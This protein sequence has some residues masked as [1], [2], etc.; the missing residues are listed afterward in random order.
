MRK[1]KYYLEIDGKSI[2]LNGD[3][4]LTDYI[5]NNIE[6]I[7][8]TPKHKIKH[9]LITK[10]QERSIEI[11]KRITS[12]DGS[13]D[14]F[15]PYKFLSK[16]HLI[17]GKQKL[18]V[19]EFRQE[20]Y[21]LKL[22]E[23]LKNEHPEWT[24]QNIKVEIDK[25]LKANS[26]MKDLAYLFKKEF[27]LRFYTKT[28]A[29]TD[30]LTSELP[31]IIKNIVLYNASLK[32]IEASEEEIKEAVKKYS[33][34]IREH[35]DSKIEKLL[36]RESLI[37]ANQDIS[38]RDFSLNSEVEM[39]AL[40]DLISIDENG[41][42]NIFEIAVS[43]V[44]YSKWDNVKKDT[45]DY[46][47]G[48]KRQL[49]SNYLDVSN[50]SLSIINIVI[51]KFDDSELINLDGF[52]INDDIERAFSVNNTAT[53]STKSQLHYTEGVISANLKLLLPSAIPQSRRPTKEFV[54]ST[55]NDLKIIFP[56]YEFKSKLTL[57]VEEEIKRVLKKNENNTEVSIYDKTNRTKITIKKDKP[58][59][60]EEFRTKVTEYVNSWNENKDSRMEGIIKD[61]TKMKR[62][63]SSNKSEFVSWDPSIIKGSDVLK[64]A[65][66][67][68][69]HPEW[70]LQNNQIDGLSQLGILLFHNTRTHSIEAVSV[71]ANELNKV[72]NLGDRTSSLLGKFKT[73]RQAE[74]L[75]ILPAKGSYIE[76]VKVL[77]ALSNLGDILKGKKLKS[78]H[79]VSLAPFKEDADIVITKTIT[80]NYNTITSVLN[81]ELEGVSLKNS[82]INNKILLADPFEELYEKIVTNSFA[83]MSAFGVQ[84]NVINI[85]KS[86]NV[87]EETPTTAEE[88]L[89]WFE[90]LQDILYNPE[91]SFYKHLIGKDEKKVGDFSDPLLYLDGLISEAIVHYKGL[92]DVFDYNIQKYGI[93]KDNWTHFTKTVLLGQAP[94]YDENGRQ[95]A[96]ILQGSMFSAPSSIGSKALRNLHELITIGHNKIASEFQKEQNKIFNASSE[97]YKDINR[98]VLERWTIGDADEYHKVFYEKTGSNLD[99]ELKFKNPWNPNSS[100]DDVQRKYLKNILF[101]MY[102]NSS[103]NKL[104]LK[105]IE[106]LEKSS[107]FEKIKSGESRLF[108]A[109]LIKKAGATRWVP[110]FKDFHKYIGRAWDAMRDEFDPKDRTEEQRAWDHN[111]INAY[112]VIYNHYDDTRD[113]DKRNILMEKYDLDHF[114]INIDTIATKYILEHIRETYMNPI[115]L[116]VK[117]ALTV[118]KM[119]GWKTNKVK[120]V[121]EALD[122]FWDQMKSYVYNEP[123]IQG[124][125]KDALIL[126]RKAQ[127]VASLMTIA[128]RPTLMAKE[129]TVGMIKNASF[130]YY[131]NYGE[132]SFGEEDLMF[133]YS[134]L[135]EPDMEQFLLNKELNF[136]YRIA[137]TDLNYLANKRKYDRFGLNFLSE[138]FYWFSTAP[139]FVNRL[140]LFFA[141]LHKDGAFDAHYLMEN[142]DLGYNPKADKR[143]SYYF[144][145]RDKYKRGREY[146]YS[147]ND[148]EFNRQ[149]SLYL[150]VIEEFNG[151][152]IKTG[153]P[154]LKEE[155]LIPQAYSSKERASIKTFIDTAYGH[156]DHTST[157]LIFN[158]VAGILFGQFLKFYPGK[159]EHYVGKRKQASGGHMGQKRQITAEGKTELLWR[160]EIIDKDGNIE[161]HEVPEQE[162]TSEDLR[163]PAMA[164]VGSPSEGLLYSLSH[165]S[166]DILKGNLK[167]EDPIRIRRAKLALHDMIL[168]LLFLWIAHSL[169]PSSKDFREMTTAERNLVKIGFKSM[170]ELDLFTSLFGSLSATPHFVSIL[171]NVTEDLR[172]FINGDMP[173][174]KLLKDN[175]RMLELLP[176]PKKL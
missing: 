36:Q 68:Y 81:R 127:R 57:N 106:E 101:L 15:N 143:Y 167:T 44:E 147:K 107:E 73:D 142:G 39:S 42:P 137:N 151:D 165:V 103:L 175:I 134:K 83:E 32:G 92:I 116:D 71:T 48:I 132:D 16:E 7:G 8:I 37:I 84:D 5:K 14:A 70:V 31:N 58:N 156:Y 163:V 79:I 43:S 82:F 129:L 166:H 34:A 162:L 126:I 17:H 111:E 91:N 55:I 131:K 169:Y 122:V 72:Y 51:P 109:P 45:E 40:A 153:V 141:K 86:L 154:L 74:A 130:A 54:A 11:F 146:Q 24:S 114:E 88:K 35:I 25:I 80:D 69:L 158:K 135:L 41:S 170:S 124:E 108:Y 6:M 1:C 95:V 171:G 149:R 89:K 110:T 119:H 172:S 90:K 33:L 27:R 161:I 19:P 53:G 164:W 97:Y 61:I 118:I 21:V 4:E 168:S 123:L 160:K 99:P 26:F 66:M 67:K 138:N 133:G 136:V 176:I 38:V 140:S 125:G 102:K 22:E 13:K 20:N 59:W 98:S 152:N 148:S 104:G 144:E 115:M 2:V 113:I 29:K 85:L 174:S 96:G 121:E 47:L 18:L 49:L 30:F 145:N 150:A 139:D 87:G 62:A 9:S 117:T 60:E 50:S 155:D 56:S 94:E 10:D 120:E 78:I 157:P 75:K 52:S 112:K 159:V 64:Q 12:F 93:S 28:G 23:K 46:I 105:T 173:I 76:A 77:S 65:L 3:F 100:L 128:L 63:N